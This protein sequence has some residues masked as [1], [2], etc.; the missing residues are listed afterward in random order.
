MKQMSYIRA[1]NRES[2]WNTATCSITGEKTRAK[3][4]PENIWNVL[5]MVFG[6]KAKK[7]FTLGIQKPGFY[8]FLPEGYKNSTLWC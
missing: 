5:P 1:K 2:D 6:T 8:C 3:D 4:P 7:H